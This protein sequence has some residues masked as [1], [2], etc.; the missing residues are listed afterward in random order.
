MLQLE[1]VIMSVTLTLLS[2]D[3]FIVR[4]VV[5]SVTED[6]NCAFSYRFQSFPLFPCDENDLCKCNLQRSNMSAKWKRECCCRH[7]VL[8]TH[9]HGSTT[10][11]PSPTYLSEWQCSTA[12]L[13][14][15]L[16]RLRKNVWH[17]LVASVLLWKWTYVCV[18]VCVWYV[19][20]RWATQ[21]AY[22]AMNQPD[23]LWKMHICFNA[24]N[25][26]HEKTDLTLISL[27]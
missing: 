23:V 18:C 22:F 2:R 25:Y 9:R 16:Y 24:K 12:P 21:M 20:N 1:S 14:C 26:I 4:C 15:S 19:V 11:I 10:H 27:R 5:G 7:L 6:R 13:N 17:L 3:C 8:A